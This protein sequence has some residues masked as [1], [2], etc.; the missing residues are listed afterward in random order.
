M[1]AELQ[2]PKGREEGG[3]EEVE[4]E[5]MEGWKREER[6]PKGGRLM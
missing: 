1:A 2:R 5:E 3:R 6:S 4:V